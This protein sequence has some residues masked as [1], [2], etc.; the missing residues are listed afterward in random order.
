MKDT[1]ST[2]FL[3]N[4][5]QYIVNFEIFHSIQ[6]LEY[7]YIMNTHK[8]TREEK[9]TWQKWRT[10]IRVGWLLFILFNA[11]HPNKHDLPNYFHNEM[12]RRQYVYLLWC[13]FFNGGKREEIK[14]IRIP[15]IKVVSILCDKIC[16]CHVLF[17]TVI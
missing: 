4:I 3:I 7:K 17:E 9:A 1:S 6:T 13:V 12:W 10:E 11:Y 14:L 15:H 8:K 2:T 5:F 16:A